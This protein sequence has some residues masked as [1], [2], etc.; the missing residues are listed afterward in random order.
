M[1]CFISKLC[2]AWWDII[3]I[4][5]LVA[6]LDKRVAQSPLGW[7]V[8]WKG[9]MWAEFSSDTMQAW[10]DTSQHT[11]YID[12]DQ[13]EPAEMPAVSFLSPPPANLLSGSGWWVLAVETL[14]DRVFIWP[15]KKSDINSLGMAS[16]QLSIREQETR[17]QNIRRDHQHYTI[18]PSHHHSTIT[19]SSHHHHHLAG[20]R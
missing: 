8:V 16:C 20:Y 3:I 14:N 10:V 17:W 7:G 18:T 19:T 12:R 1:L 9:A 4:T 13:E 11:D 5:T 6:R 2:W 15:V